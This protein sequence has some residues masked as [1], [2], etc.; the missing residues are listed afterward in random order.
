VID[1]TDQWLEERI[2]KVAKDCRLE[3]HDNPQFLNTREDL[4]SFFRTGKKSFFQTTFYK[5]QRKKQVVLVDEME[6][7][8]GASGPTTPRTARSIPKTKSHPPSTFRAAPIC[9]TR[10]LTMCM[11]I[12]GIIPGMRGRSGYIPSRT[13]RQQSGWIN[14]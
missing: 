14:S 7:P 4:A 12:S 10:L 2:R 3:I 11:H 8:S 6:T 9:G 1:P 5:Q 13:G